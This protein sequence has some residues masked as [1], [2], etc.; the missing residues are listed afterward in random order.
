[1]WRAIH[2]NDGHADT[3]GDAAPHFEGDGVHGNQEVQG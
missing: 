1:V 3:T 2:Q